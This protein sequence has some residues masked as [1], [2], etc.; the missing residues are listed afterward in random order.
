MSVC[1]Y[2]LTVVPRRDALREL[3]VRDLAQIQHDGPEAGAP[4]HRRQHRPR[5]RHHLD[6]EAVQV[7]LAQ[8]RRPPQLVV[9]AA[10][11]HRAGDHVARVGDVL[12]RSAAHRRVS[13]RVGDGVPHGGAGRY[14]PQ[15]V[16]A[17]VQ[18]P[19]RGLVGRQVGQ[20]ADAVHIEQRVAH[21]QLDNLLLLLLLL[22]R[23]VVPLGE[24]DDPALLPD[25]RRRERRAPVPA[26]VGLLLAQKGPV[27]K[28]KETL[29]APGPR[30]GARLG[31]AAIGGARRAEELHAQLGGGGAGGG[32]E[33]AGDVEEVLAELVVGAGDALAAEPDVGD[34]VEAVEEQVR[35]R[36]SGSG[37]AVLLLLE[38]AGQSGRVVPVRP[39]HPSEIE[40]V[41]AVVGVSDHLGG[42]QVQMHVRGHLARD[43]DVVERVREGPLQRGEFDDVLC[44]GMGEEE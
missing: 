11:D 17:R 32:G 31:G 24:L 1:M 42:E 41:E 27:H 2:A 9:R 29:D 13:R 35:R 6:G 38:E 12:Q 26:E 16:D 15:H 14:R 10:Q 44:G 40:V 36:G 7:L 30:L 39:R 43:G 21:R 23:L 22:C 4:L 18:H 19:V 3:L 33:G 37:V 8:P 25:A 5:R 28:L 34:G 20:L